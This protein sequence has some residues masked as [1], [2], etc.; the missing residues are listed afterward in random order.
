MSEAII[1]KIV[2]NSEIEV[3]RE[4]IEREAEMMFQILN[5]QLMYQAMENGDYGSL[6]KLDRAEQMQELRAEAEEQI[7]TKMVL[8]SIVEAQQLEVTIEELEEEARAIASRQRIPIE[9]VKSFLGEGLESLRSDL[10]MRKAI[11]FVCAMQ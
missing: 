2:D 5:H 7:K 4:M 10:L 3:P 11:D 6:M 9:M 8:K 1:R